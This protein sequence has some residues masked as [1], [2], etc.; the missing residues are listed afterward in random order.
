MAVVGLVREL[1][2]REL[3]G[4]TTGFAYVRTLPFRLLAGIMCELYFD[5]GDVSVR[6][7]LLIS[8]DLSS[9]SLFE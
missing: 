2:S 7:R 4:N 5:C 1:A 9:S 3:M 8:L 6:E